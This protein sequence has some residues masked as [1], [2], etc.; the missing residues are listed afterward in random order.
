MKTKRALLLLTASILLL[1]WSQVRAQED[2]DDEAEALTEIPVVPVA[3][4]ETPVE[5]V[6]VRV[7]NEYEE[8]E[9]SPTP[10]I[11]IKSI[12]PAQGPITGK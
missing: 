11:R 9:N 8:L 5:R 10:L 4:V 12:F 7:V 6:K 3:P 2:D 1:S